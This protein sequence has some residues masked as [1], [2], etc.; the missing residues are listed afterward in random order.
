MALIHLLISILGSFPAS[1]LISGQRTVHTIDFSAVSCEELQDF[2]VPFSFRIDQTGL[3]F[4]WLFI[5]C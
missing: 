3:Y 4:L 2:E 5:S 1:A